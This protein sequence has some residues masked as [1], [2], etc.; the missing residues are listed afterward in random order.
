[1]QRARANWPEGL[2]VQM[3]SGNAAFRERDFDTALRH[4]HRATEIA[5]DIAATWF[6]IYMTE[7]ERGNAAAA[8]SAMQRARALAPDASLIH[9]A[10]PPTTGHQP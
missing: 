8:D 10:E 2:A 6:G 4:Y 7:A 9:P 3:D 1:M 5:P